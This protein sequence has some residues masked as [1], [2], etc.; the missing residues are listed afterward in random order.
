MRRRAATLGRVTEKAGPKRAS[1][2][3]VA[4]LAALAA[5]RSG[6]AD[7]KDAP[8]VDAALAGPAPTHEP[9]DAAAAPVANVRREWDHGTVEERLAAI[10]VTS[11]RFARRDLYSWTTRSQVAEVRQSRR[12]LVARANDGP[13][14]PFVWLVDTL[15]KKHDDDGAIAALLARDPRFERRRYAW[16][17]G[18]AT[19]L[20]LLEKRYGDELVHVRLR[21][22]TIV[23][24]LDPARSPAFVA[25]DLDDHEVPLADVIADPSRIGAVY[26]VRRGT[27]VPSPFREY[28]IVSE[29]AVLGYGIGTAH[30][31]A[32]I[33]AE[34]RLVRELGTRTEATS[35]KTPRSS[36]DRARSFDHEL[37]AGASLAERWDR[38]L[39][40]PIVRYELSAARLDDVV[41]ALEGYH[42]TSPP[43]ESPSPGA[44]DD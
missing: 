31:R 43:I 20:G 2:V 29:G 33:D 14:S 1:W 12:L 30:V 7:G 4:A 18:F 25:H 3:A 15:A 6:A 24:R 26:H 32:E 10:A 37:G 11:S 39:A 17:A 8:I 13:K 28:V 27:D 40:F 16:T 19:V 22:D 42:A 5:C 35:R 21:P 36:R 9:A 34:K 41:S 44:L 38:A 23:L